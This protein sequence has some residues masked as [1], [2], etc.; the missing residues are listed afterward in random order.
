MEIDPEGQQHD[1]TDAVDSILERYTGAQLQQQEQQ[2]AR[3][4]EQVTISFQASI[5]K[6][7][8]T[9]IEAL[10][11]VRNAVVSTADQS[12]AVNP[13]TGILPVDSI[14][15]Q[16]HLATPDGHPKV[17]VDSNS[18]QQEGGKQTSP[19]QRSQ[20]SSSSHSRTRSPQGES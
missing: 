14:T 5:E 6:L 9:L 3:M 4:T 17:L 11:P 8:S 2:M 20:L 12:A 1:V 7:T 19:S 18:A 13:S 16:T 10:T 15:D